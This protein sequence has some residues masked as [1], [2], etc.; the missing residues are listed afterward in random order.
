MNV[1]SGR[2]I[3]AIGGPVTD[4]VAGSISREHRHATPVG[5]D[6]DRSITS[7][8]RVT[9]FRRWF[10]ALNRRRGRQRAVIVMYHSFTPGG[11]AAIAPDTLRWHLELLRDDYA[12]VPLSRLVA[13]LANREPTD[14]MAAITVDDGYEDFVTVAY[15]MLCELRLPATLF[16]PTGFI[17][18]HSDWYDHER[19]PI[20]I[21]SERLLRDVDRSLVTLGSHSV[22]HRP[23]NGARAETLEAEIRRSK[24][25][26]ESLVNAPVTLFA[27]PS[28][29]RASYTANTVRALHAAGFV[30]AVTT[31]WE[32]YSSH[33]ELMSLP[34]VSF[35]E[36]DGPD[37]VRAKLA[38]D[39]DWVKFRELTAHF[40]RSALAKIR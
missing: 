20:P 11:W 2:A 33:R 7:L 22:H 31:S 21:A 40:G 13:A 16:V 5:L 37:E 30:A 35:L 14:R 9:G 34:R 6:L 39:F 3:S 24:S 28:G 12:V 25:D 29:G 18:G 38:G 15:P 23:L 4:A 10:G 8:L 26:L 19:A 32:T 1:R 36:I 27:Y 17:G